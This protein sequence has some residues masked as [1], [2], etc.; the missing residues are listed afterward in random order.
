MSDNIRITRASNKSTHPGTPDIDEE[1]LSRPMPK[2]RRTKAQIAADNAAAAK[3]KSTKAEEVR[4]NEEKKALLMA[5]IAAL[6]KQMGDDEKQD[7]IDAAHPPAKKMV[8]VVKSPTVKG[9]NAH[10]LVIW[11]YING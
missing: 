11:V 5:Q 10:L 2:P 9:M 1:V 8:F 3:M 7:E 4:L 6:E